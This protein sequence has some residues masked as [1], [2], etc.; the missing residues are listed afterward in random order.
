MPQIATIGKD[1]AVAVHVAM[2]QQFGL[3]EHIRALG[4]DRGDDKG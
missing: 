2:A 1:A 3:A 4:D